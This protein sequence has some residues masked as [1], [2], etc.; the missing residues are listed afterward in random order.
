MW[1]IARALVAVRA[2]DGVQRMV[3]WIWRIE[4]LWIWRIGRPRG[5]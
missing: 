2:T 3:W 4:E 1:V 5:A